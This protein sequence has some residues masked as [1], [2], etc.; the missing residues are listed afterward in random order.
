MP[1]DFSAMRQSVVDGAP[2]TAA[3]LA[4][5][6]LAAGVPPLDS[7]D[8]GFAP[9]MAEVG[10]QYAQRKMFLPDMLA[11][12]EAMK[13]AMSILEPELTKQ[14][15]QR[16]IAGTV[17]LGTTKGDIHEIGKTL[18]GTLLT[19]NGFKVHDL[20][21]D[22]ASEEFAA[23]AVELKADVVGVSALLTTTMRGQKLVVEALHR[24]GLRPGVKVIVGGAPVTKR[25][26]EEIGADGYAKDAITA[27]A[28]VRT[29]LDHGSPTGVHADK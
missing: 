14:G 9:G 5:A 7:I 25:W 28:L 16:P 22:V 18:V 2:E 13:A 10:E 21:V 15:E 26:A 27:V 29:L 8:Q 12:A 24:A 23:K 3:H 1:G 4:Q 11:S 17:I 20:G 19:A 6:A